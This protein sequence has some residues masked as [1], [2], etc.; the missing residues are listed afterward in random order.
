MGIFL[1]AYSKQP[2]RQDL[3]HLH[4]AFNKALDLT[5][6][7]VLKFEKLWVLLKHRLEYPIWD[8]RRRLGYVVGE[9]TE[10]RM[11]AILFSQISIC[12]YWEAS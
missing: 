4:L 2:G 1:D 7:N 6:S 9:K 10:N 11:I 3:D 5:R 8:W 12:I